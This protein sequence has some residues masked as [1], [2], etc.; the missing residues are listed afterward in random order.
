MFNRTPHFF[1]SNLLLIYV[2]V[3]HCYNTS[4]NRN[5]KMSSCESHPN[6]RIVTTIQ[7]IT[8]K[9]EMNQFSLVL[10]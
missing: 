2:T 8:M 1:G 10:L 5:N 4:V 9:R 6:Y 7:M 3:S